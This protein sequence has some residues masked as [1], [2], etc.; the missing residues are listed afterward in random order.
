MTVFEY[1]IPSIDFR[2][3]ID[4]RSDGLYLL[5]FQK[6]D[7]GKSWPWNFPA[8]WIEADTETI[9]HLYQDIAEAKRDGNA[10]MI[11]RAASEC[12]E[13]SNMKVVWYWKKESDARKLPVN[14]LIIYNERFEEIWNIKDFLERS[15]MCTGIC[16]LDEETFSFQTFSCEN[17]VM[18]ILDGKVKC[19]HRTL[20]R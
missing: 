13:I 6:W 10:F 1:E 8:D 14:N 17:I 4:K 16:V 19:F 3:L 11:E 7:D 20:T 2:Y 15:E 9:V 5:K 18:K 12:I